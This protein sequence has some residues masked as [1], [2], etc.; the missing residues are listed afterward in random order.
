MTLG[1]VRIVA[2]GTKVEV[3]ADDRPLRG[4]VDFTVRG[5]V[6]D[7]VR[8]HIELGLH[9]F[10]CDAAVHYVMRNPRTGEQISVVEVM[11]ADGRMLDL[12]TGLISGGEDAAG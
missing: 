6:G 9:D 10:E 11:L 12:R 8:A 3:L 4:V 2:K 7:I 1:L 5:Q